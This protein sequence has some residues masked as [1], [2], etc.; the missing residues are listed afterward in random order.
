MFR[1]G[2][3]VGTGI[4]SGIVDRTHAADGLPLPKEDEIINV[5]EKVVENDNL[6][7]LVILLLT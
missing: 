6:K 7:I 3:N 5:N 2:G 4:M 1:I